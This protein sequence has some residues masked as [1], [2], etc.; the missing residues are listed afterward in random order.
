[1]N[2]FRNMHL[3]VEVAASG[4]FRAAALR[5]DMPSSTLSRRIAELERDIGLRLLH[6][7]TR[8]VELTEAGKLY[9]ERCRRIIGEAQL[10]HE[11]L[12]GMLTQPTGTIRASVPV[13]FT[14]IYLSD[15]LA[16][17]LE[18]YP[19]IKLELDVTPRQGNLVSDPFDLTIRIGE[20]KEQSLIARKLGYVSSSLFAA[21]KYLAR[22]GS[23]KQPGD[24]IDHN[25]LRIYERAWALT[26]R[27]TGFQDIVPVTGTVIA[28]NVGLIRK[29]A[30]QGTGIAA[31]TKELANDDVD[32]G[33]LLPILTNWHLPDISVY[34]LTETRL[35]PAKVRVFIDF[36]IQNLKIKIDAQLV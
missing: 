34:A 23:P 25:C 6:R 21:P 29:L 22:F 18:L 19:G 20:P 9:F 17:F 2:A 32:Q 15:I 26:D 7:T 27:Q 10:A 36:L 24:L 8:H 14:I 5:L 12:S 28:N 4:G 16:D 11:E 33:R 1:M 31:L 35:V 13:D 3:F 30:I